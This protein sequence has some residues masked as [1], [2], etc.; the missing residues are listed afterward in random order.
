MTIQEQVV[1]ATNKYLIPN[2]GRLS[3]AMVRG[4]GA[5]ICDASGKEYVDFFAGFGAGGVAG[6]CHPDVVAAIRHQADHLMCCGNL[7][8]NEPQ[9]Q[10]AEAITRHGFGGKVF[11]CHSGAEANEAALKL[12]RLA[13]GE[14]KYK[15]ISF[16]HCF[17]GRTMGSLSLTPEKYQ[18][19]F[20]PM[21]PGNVKCLYDVIGS[22]EKAIDDQ[23][24]GVIVEPI[25]GEGGV[26]VPSVKFMQGLRR[27][28]TDRKL[29][30]ICD[31]VWTS[32]ARTG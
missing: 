28:C 7:F 4:A 6:H 30:L 20:E 23:A 12:A 25:Q 8:T 14:G 27:L 22:V 29:S 31:E 24:A 10:L 13:A 15:I 11:F 2:Y 3:V 17:H 26:N 21:V 1:D 5:R 9:V 19:G 16:D 32:P 18:K